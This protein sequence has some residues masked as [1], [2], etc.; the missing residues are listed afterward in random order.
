MAIFHIVS[1]FAL[2]KSGHPMLIQPDLSYV[3]QF[4]LSVVLGI[5][6]SPS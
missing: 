2:T 3:G 6:Q 5:T 1:F 4:T